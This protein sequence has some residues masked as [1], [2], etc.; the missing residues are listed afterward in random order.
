MRF[1]PD[2]LPIAWAG[3]GAALAGLA[4]AIWARIH[5]GHYWSDKII[6]KVDHELIRSGPYAYMRHPIYS[7]VLF[8]VFGTALLLG[9]VRGLLAFS[10]LLINYAIKAKREERILADHFGEQFRAYT[11]RAGFLLPRLHRTKES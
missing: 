8:G 6:L 10:L 5:L 4:I 7:G 9:E 1:I 3:L 11:S 2:S